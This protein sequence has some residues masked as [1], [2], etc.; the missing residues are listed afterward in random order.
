[1]ELTIKINTEEIKERCYKQLEAMYHDQVNKEDLLHDFELW[2]E[3]A[4]TDLDDNFDEF[5]ILG[6]I[7]SYKDIVLNSK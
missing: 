5:I 6:L 1:M 4:P 7:E 2:W 3:S